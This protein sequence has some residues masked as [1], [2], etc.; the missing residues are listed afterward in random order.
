MP[1]SSV[2]DVPYQYFLRIEPFKISPRDG[3][4]LPKQAINTEN[5]MLIHLKEN[6]KIIK[7]TFC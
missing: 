6:K 5:W 1:V 4:F 3:G 2:L 7:S